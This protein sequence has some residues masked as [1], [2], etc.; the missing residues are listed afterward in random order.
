MKPT[1]EEIEEAV[2]ERLKCLE[3]EVAQS[4]ARL[5]GLLIAA[6]QSEPAKFQNIYNL[7]REASIPFS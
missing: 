4:K 2:K 7:I 3:E 5:Q 6:R 1:T